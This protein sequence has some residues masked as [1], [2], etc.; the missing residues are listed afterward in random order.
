MSDIT[1]SIQDLILFLLGIGGIILIICLIVL[2]KN[3]IA[4]V[5]STNK[6]LKDAE[7]ISKIAAGR[8]KD[9]DGI[10]DDV[11]ES[12]GVLAKNLKGNGGFLKTI[13]SAVSLITSL[14]GMFSGKTSSDPDEKEKKD[15]KDKKN[16]K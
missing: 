14:K 13:A 16:T 7:S 8:A 10:I 4:T 1:I 11:T 12:V 2:A 3:L 15:A 5:K 6:I 9:V